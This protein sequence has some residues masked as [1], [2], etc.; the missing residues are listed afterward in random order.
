MYTVQHQYHIPTGLP[1]REEGWVEGRAERPVQGLWCAVPASDRADGLLGK[2][3]NPAWL[4]MII[5][6]GILNIL[7]QTQMVESWT[8]R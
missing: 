5:F 8:S 7:G 6:S 3:P 2:Q 1:G 4:I